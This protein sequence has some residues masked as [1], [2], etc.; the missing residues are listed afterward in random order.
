MVP[1]TSKSLIHSVRLIDP[2]TRSHLQL[3]T[4]LEEPRSGKPWYGYL[5]VEG[6]R[7]AYPI[8][9]GVLRLGSRIRERDAAWIAAEGL[10]LPDGTALQ[11]AASVESFGFQWAWDSE[12]RTE[13]DLRWRV[14]ERFGIFEN[15]Y[16]GKLVL[17]AGCGAGDQSRWLVRQGARV[18]GVDLSDAIEVAS[19]KLGDQPSWTGIQGDV[20]RFPFDDHTFD[21][22]YC[23][24][25]IQHTRNSEETVRELCRVL[26]PGGLICATHYGMPHGVLRR[27]RHRIEMWRRARLSRWDRYNLLGYSALLAALGE[28]PVLG[29]ILK[30]ARVVIHNPR[31]DDFKSNWSCTYDNFGSHSFQR[32]I[33]VE[34]FRSYF[35]RCGRFIEEYV[36][37]EEPIVRLRKST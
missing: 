29:R 10:S 12:P 11:D 8:S 36:S 22:I 2:V 1:V 28:I 30:K 16:E 5:N 13:A 33:T 34:E 27:A 15:L 32:Y 9:E 26:K 24:G 35:E 4:L 6:T 3:R 7:F 20:T 17:D 23:E 21:I 19:R 31:M 37:T 25:V 14:A 18:V